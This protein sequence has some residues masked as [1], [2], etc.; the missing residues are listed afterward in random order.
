M[1]PDQ[2]SLSVIKKGILINTYLYFEICITLLND[3]KY[4]SVTFRALQKIKKFE[5]SVTITV[6]RRLRLANYTLVF[7]IY[8]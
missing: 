7:L 6:G 5:I 8:M 4:K 1:Y 2:L 3:Q